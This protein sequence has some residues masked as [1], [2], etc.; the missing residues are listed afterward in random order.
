M[1]DSNAFDINAVLDRLNGD[2]Q[3]VRDLLDIFL[4]YEGTMLGDICRAIAAGDHQAIGF[5]AHRAKG[6]LVSIHAGAACD[7][8]RQVEQAATNSEDTAALGVELTH[9]W[10]RLCD[11]LREYLQLP[12]QEANSVSGSC[13]DNFD[14]PRDPE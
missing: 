8:C 10:N 11:A 5:S 9:E 1:P 2:V 3:H 14:L 7:V 12:E 13:P 6:A 4:S